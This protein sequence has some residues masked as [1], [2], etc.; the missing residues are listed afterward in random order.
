MA[1]L[2]DYETKNTFVATLR[3]EEA[4]LPP[5]GRDEKLHKGESLKWPD[6]TCASLAA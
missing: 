2:S 5:A 3:I 4:T 1:F 6:L